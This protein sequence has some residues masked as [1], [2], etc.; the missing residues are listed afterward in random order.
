MFREAPWYGYKVTTCELFVY[1]DRAKVLLFFGT[2]IASSWLP[3]SRVGA[4]Y[5]YHENTVLRLVWYISVFTQYSYYR[6]F[7][8]LW[9]ASR[10]HNQHCHVWVRYIHT[11]N[12]TVACMSWLILSIDL[13]W[14]CYF[15]M[16][17]FKLTN[18]AMD[19]W[20]MVKWFNGEIKNGTGNF[21]PH[22]YW[23]CS[24]VLFSNTTFS[25]QSKQFIIL[26]IWQLTTSTATK[27][28][29]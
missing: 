5:W 8:C 18:G 6:D 3:S 2:T 27:C 14:I 9:P 22:K 7:F 15:I 26:N 24:F 16:F 21:F 10:L 20:G 13:R 1:L 25:Q 29:I 19:K 28:I 23:I 17:C 4:L 12:I 11:T